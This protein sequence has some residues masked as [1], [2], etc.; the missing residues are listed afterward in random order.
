[1][2]QV[3]GKRLEEL[4]QCVKEAHKK[5]R[6][7]RCN[8]CKVMP[9]NLDHD[10]YKNQRRKSRSDDKRLRRGQNEEESRRMMMNDANDKRRMSHVN[11]NSD[12]K[13]L[14]CVQ[15]DSKTSFVLKVILEK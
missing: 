9:Q 12:S 13:S 3:N 10:A 8:D 1:M 4:K 11:V 15:L 2:N 6:R 7:S 5:A 14:L